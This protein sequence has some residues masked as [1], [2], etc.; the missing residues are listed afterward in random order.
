MIHQPFSRRWLLTGASVA[1][2]AAALG[3]PRAPALARSEMPA[4]QAPYMYRFKL[5]DAQAT[6]ISDGILPLGAPGE[7]FLGLSAQE[8]NKELTDNFLRTD[9]IVLE[10]NLLVLNIGDK[11]VLFDSGMGSSKLFGPTTGRMMETMK[12]A[13][14]D[15]KGV[16]AVVMSH[17]HIDHCGGLMSADDQRN[18]PNAQLYITQADYDYWTD[19]AKVGP[20]LKAFLDHAN[21]NLVPNKDRIHFI[22][23]HEE[24]LPGVTAM[25]AP[26]H[27]IG[28]TIFMINSGGQSLCYIADLSHHP[29]L[30]LEHPLTEFAY[31]TDPKQSAQSRVR[32][33]TMLADNRVPILAYH[34]AWPG[35]GHVV[36]DGDGFRYLPEPMEMMTLA[37]SEG[38]SK[39]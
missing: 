8:I 13:G 34:F 23:D 27:T 18:F 32:M 4:A 29:V 30:L 17:A 6:I 24:I 25:L 39:Y 19:P 5:G 9:N 15:P 38:A 2:A 26:G 22:K 3:L 20:K 7:A 16:D 12:A 37:S 36:K 11:T 14:I 21:K 1:T 28:H 35:V 10:Q 33:L 31:D